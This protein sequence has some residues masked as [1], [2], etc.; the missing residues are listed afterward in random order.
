MQYAGKLFNAFQ[1]LHRSDE[2]DGTGIGLSIVH[3]VVA[4]H[5]GKVW[6]DAAVGRGARFYFTLG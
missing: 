1:R 2:F 3:R 5:G 4:K 6:A